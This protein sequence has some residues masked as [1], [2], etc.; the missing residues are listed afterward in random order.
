MIFVKKGVQFIRGCLIACGVFASQ[1]QVAAQTIKSVAIDFQILT[2]IRP[3]AHQPGTLL[4]ESDTF[5]LQNNYNTVT[6][7]G[8]ELSVV[9]A[10]HR[11][12]AH[13]AYHVGQIVQ[14]ARHWVG[15]DWTSLSIP[16]GGSEAFR[17]NP[18]P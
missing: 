5:S 18:R 4:Y 8:L 2:E 12:L 3:V 16:R 14:L 11:S 7:R 1:G 17:A 15:S 9:A 13:T 6:I 10:L